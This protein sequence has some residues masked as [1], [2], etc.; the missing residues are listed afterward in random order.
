LNSVNGVDKDL[1][2]ISEIAKQYSM[3]SLMSNLTGKSGEYDCAGK[4]S[5]WDKQGILIGQLN[6]K[7]EGVIIIDTENQ[8]IIE[9]YL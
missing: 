5:I 9:K 3:I 1:K 7:E 8:E 6:E 2:R 4:T